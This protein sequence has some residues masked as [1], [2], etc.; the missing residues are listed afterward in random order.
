VA[1]RDVQKNQLVGPFLLVASRHFHGISG[2]PEVDKI[3]S[4]H[5]PPSIHVEAGDDAFGEHGFPPNRPALEN[6]LE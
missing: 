1:G 6:R 5:H 3:G 4:L 2:I